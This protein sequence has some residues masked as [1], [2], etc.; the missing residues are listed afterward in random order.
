MLAEGD[1]SPLAFLF[2]PLSLSLNTPW[3]CRGGGFKR[4]LWVSSPLA[5]GRREGCMGEVWTTHWEGE[6]VDRGQWRRVT[7]FS[8]YWGVTAPVPSAT[9]DGT[10][11]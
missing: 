7:R 2:W 1:L 6:R 3:S 4:V 8:C 9:E 5:S 11:D 10:E